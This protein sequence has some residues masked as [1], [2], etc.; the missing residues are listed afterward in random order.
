MPVEGGSEAVSVLSL[1][2]S[3]DLLVFFLMEA[4]GTADAALFLLKQ[5]HSVGVLAA[6][7]LVS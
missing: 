2:N 1:P 7:Q 6:Q 5:A 3:D 4:R